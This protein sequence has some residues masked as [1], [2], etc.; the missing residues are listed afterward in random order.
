MDHIS[1]GPA[2]SPGVPS[3]VLFT[4]IIITKSTGLKIYS[5]DNDYR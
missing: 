3:S 4:V 2:S 5:I 1:H